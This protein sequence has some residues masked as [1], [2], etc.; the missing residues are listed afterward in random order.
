M[1]KPT[2]VN[3]PRLNVRLWNRAVDPDN[4][5]WISIAEP[6]LA[7][8]IVKN[9]TL[10][11][12][13]NLKVE[14]WDI[15]EPLAAILPEDPPFLP[16]DKKDAAQIVDFILAHKGKNFLINCQAG[17][18]RSGAVCQFLEECL[19]YEWN[20]DHKKLARPNKLLLQMMK[21]YFY[22]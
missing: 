6:G 16:P 20:A 17:I 18:S 22:A 11:K 14:F 9:T 15:I 21:D 1:N 2:C 12:L 19:D 4:D 13:P 10:D 7:D 8:T 5:V 3:L